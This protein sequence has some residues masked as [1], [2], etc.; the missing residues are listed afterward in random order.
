MAQS[1][2]RGLDLPMLRTFDAL[3]REGS[4]SRAAS[5]LFLSQPA[6]SASLK[7]LREV[8]DDPLFTRTGHGV[9]P[10][11]RA[12]ALAPRVEA[13]L[14]EMHKLMSLEQT[15][16]PATSDRILRIMG[17]DHTCRVMLPL[18]CNE[19][20]QRGSRIRLSWELADYARLTER[21]RKGDVDVGLHPRLSPAAGVESELLYE[22]SYVTVARHGHPALSMPLDLEAFC[23]APHAVLGQ[24]RSVLDDTVDQALARKGR[25]RHVQAAVTTFNQMVDLMCHSDV[26]AVFPQ[27]VARH[28]TEQLAC[29][30]PP[31]ELPN[32]RLYVCWAERANADPAVLWLKDEILRMGQAMA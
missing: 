29:A 4:V 23:T 7:R 8:F 14:N 12:L 28:Y 15:F 2:I 13:V 10:T 18:L 31:I 16:D 22:D 17:S 30:A 21:L 1:D 24:T 19:L 11:P 3:L 26:I 27:R 5:R 20:S 6:V 25:E 9:M 32:Y